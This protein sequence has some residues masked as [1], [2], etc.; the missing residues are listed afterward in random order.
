[1]SEQDRQV[2]DHNTVKKEA[3]EENAE[4]LKAIRD[5]F[6]DLER[7]FEDLKRENVNLERLLRNHVDGENYWLNKRSFFR[8]L[9]IIALLLVFSITFI[10]I[11]L[12]SKANFDFLLY[13]LSAAIFVFSLLI[14]VF[15]IKLRKSLNT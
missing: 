1:M 5:Y 7:E 2:G 9:S 3:P 6:D 13:I 14:V 8:I 12:I 11:A 10:V 15:R 4:R